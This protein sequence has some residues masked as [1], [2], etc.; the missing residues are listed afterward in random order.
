MT[1]KEMFAMIATVNA[2]NAEIVEFCEKEIALLDK[3]KSSKTPTK[4][5]KENEVV[6]DNIALALEG[7]EEG[8]TVTEILKSSEDFK[9]TSSQKISALLRKMIDAGRVEKTMKGKKAIFSLV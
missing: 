2:D 8:A 6:M 1:K 5:Q 9:D 4:T 7:F 3:R